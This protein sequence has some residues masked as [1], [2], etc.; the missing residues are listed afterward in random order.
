MD[1]NEYLTQDEWQNVKKKISRSLRGAGEIIAKINEEE[2]IMAEKRKFL[3]FDTFLDG[4]FSNPASSVKGLL[5][6]VDASRE[7]IKTAINRSLE[8]GTAVDIEIY[9]PGSI[10]PVFAAGEI[11]WTKKGRA[12]WTYAFESGIRL[13]KID[14]LDRQRILD[15]A[16]ENWKQTKKKQ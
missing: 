12:G 11:M 7:G 3:R 2:R 5:M 15:Y 4:T 10:V 8:K 14:A 16:Y 13:S 6:V 1:E 9:F